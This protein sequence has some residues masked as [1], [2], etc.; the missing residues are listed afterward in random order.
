MK[1]YVLVRGGLWA[2]LTRSLA[3]ELLDRAEEVD[4]TPSIRSG[5][6]VFAIGEPG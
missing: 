3:I 1:P 6:A 2:R 4:G 5:E